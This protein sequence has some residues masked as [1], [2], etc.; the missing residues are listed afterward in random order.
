MKALLFIN[1]TP[2]QKLTDSS[3]YQ[4]IACTD[5][6]Y[7]YLKEKGFPLDQLDFV[8]GDFDSY[9]REEEALRGTE[10]FSFE[11]IHTPDQNKT[12]FRKALEVLIEK[13]ISEVDVYGGSGRE[14]DHF[15]GNLTTAFSLRNKLKI[16][17]FDEFS[18]YFFSPKELVLRNMKGKMISLY[19]FPLVENITTHGLNWPLKNDTLEMT[20]RIG[21]RNYAVEDTVRIKYESGA[22]LVF[23]GSDYL[24]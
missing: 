24:K 7:H 21:T 8:S 3:G 12:D 17:F 20:N 1:G 13:Q 4:I 10:K 11:I 14:M 16:T 6:A 9:S 19:P 22:L 2:P 18:H 5:G 15:L 23:V